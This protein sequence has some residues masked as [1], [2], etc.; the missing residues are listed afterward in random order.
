MKNEKAAKHDRDATTPELMYNYGIFLI[1][2]S[3]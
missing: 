2:N 1:S 3:K